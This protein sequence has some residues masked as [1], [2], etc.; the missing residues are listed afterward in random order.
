M[1]FVCN[2]RYVLEP[3]AADEAE[4]Y[5]NLL[6]DCMEETYS[7]IADPGF[8]V[9]RRAARDESIEE[10]MEEVNGP[11]VRCF[12]AY[13]VPRWTSQGGLSCAVGADIEWDAPVG[14][15][16]SSLGPHEWESE[17][18]VVPVVAGTRDLSQLYTRA[19]TH[20]TGLGEALLRAVLADDEP[21]YL[22]YIGGNERAKRFYEKFGFQDEGIFGECGGIWGVPHGEP[23][24]PLQTARMFRGGVVLQ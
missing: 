1:G 10:F 14:L 5:V 3:A 24:Q 22:W 11:G 2:G 7:A 4:K 18:P 8:M 21:A 12:L 19:T 16:L 23:G 9:R 15:A 6:H 17:M 13:E 20:G